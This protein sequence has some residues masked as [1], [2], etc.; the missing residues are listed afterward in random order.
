[1][2]QSDL[3]VRLSTYVVSPVTTAWPNS[4][5]STGYT[6]NC[7]RGFLITFPPYVQSFT[8][9]T[10]V[11]AAGSFFAGGGAAANL[12]YNNRTSVV[13]GRGTWNIRAGVNAFGGA[14]GML[15]KYG[16]EYRWSVAGSPTDY[17]GTSSW[18]M[19]PD[20][21]RGLYQTQI[22]VGTMNTPLFQNPFSKTAM[23]YKYDTYGNLVPGKT[24]TLTAV[25]EGTLWTTGQVGNLASAGEYNTSLWRTGYDNRTAGGLGRI[26]LVTPTITHWNSAGGSLDTHSA[27]VGF[28]TIRVPEPGAVLLLAVGAG[29]L[30]VLHR[31]SRRG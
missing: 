5:A 21:G 3:G 28:L 29:V 16:A 14:M 9:A 19:I 2:Q 22:G 25:G 12:G 7:C 30:V 11:N 4:S 17:Q 15:G 20:I 6:P 23:W 26:Q 10:F 31:V 13:A 27:Q 8:Y 18:A 24:S 1:M